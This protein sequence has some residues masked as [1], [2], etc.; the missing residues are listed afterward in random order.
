M[1]ASAKGVGIHDAM[2]FTQERFGGA[3]WPALLSTMSRDDQQVLSS[4][5][6]V[7][8][9]D[10]ALYAR[11]LNRLA[12][13]H[14]RGDLSLLEELG[15]FGAEH[16]LSTMQRLFMRV[17]TPGFILDQTMKLW[18]R[19]QDSGTWRVERTD[20]RAVGTLTGWGLADAALCRELLGYIHGMISHGKGEDVRVV[21]PQCRAHG[22]SACVFVGTWR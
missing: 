20:H 8:W 17:V 21:H 12:D 16:D 7:G 3:A 10:L 6:A 1:V 4:I 22:A 19:F 15:R 18:S 11:L 14:G 9:Y 2:L 5:V 13:V